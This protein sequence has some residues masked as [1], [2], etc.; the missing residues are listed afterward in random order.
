MMISKREY[1]RFFRTKIHLHA[2]AALSLAAAF[3]ISACLAQS[4]GGQ[5]A[6]EKL[7][8][9]LVLTRHGVRSPT[10]TNERLDEYS[11]EVWPK[12]DVAPGIL[13]PH[14]KK[15]MSIF[16]TYYRAAFS[17]RGLLSPDGC[18][19]AAHVYFYSDTDERTMET[20]HGLAEG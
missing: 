13:T 18:S 9:A 11:K 5:A 7:K 20:A 3:G 17:G 10:W 8:F 1:R 4:T 19:D 2:W 15:L 14:G 16:G 12:W 6:G